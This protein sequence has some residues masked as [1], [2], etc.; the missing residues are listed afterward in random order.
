[1]KYI[2]QPTNLLIVALL[3]IFSACQPSDS[4]DNKQVEETTTGMYASEIPITTSSDDAL[5][6]FEMGLAIYDQGNNQKA[7]AYF[8]KAIEL[9][10]DFVSAYMYRAFCANTWKE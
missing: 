9:D 7:K 10:P 4:T 3:F 8:D 2:N 1:M 6:Q 5:A